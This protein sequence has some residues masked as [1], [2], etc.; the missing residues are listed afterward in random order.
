M[1]KARHRLSAAKPPGRG[2]RE[3][4]AEMNETFDAIRRGRVDAVVVSAPGGDKVFTLQGAEHPYRVLVEAMNEGAATLDL[5]GTVLYANV[6]F[7]EMLRV[8]LERLIGSELRQ[9]VR[10]ESRH[11]IRRILAQAAHRTTRTQVTVITHE[12]Q[13]K[14]LRISLSPVHDSDPPTICAVATEL[15]ELVEANE[16]LKA[17]E[18][19]LRRLSGRLLQ[20]QD[21]ERRHIAR[22]LH[23]VTGQKVA[24]QAMTLSHVL[25]DH[26]L[27]NEDTRRSLSECLALT[28]QVANEIR[29]LSYLLHPPLL[30]ELGL[31]SA[32]KWY[33]QGFEARTG[34]RVQVAVPQ[35]FPRLQPDV[36]VALFRVLQESLTNV[37]RYS[38]SKG[39]RIALKVDSSR[40][41]LRVEDFGK[42]IDPKL[43]GSLKTKQGALG[44][45]IQGMRERL[46]Q[47]RGSLD[48]LSPKSGGTVVNAIVPLRL[49]EEPFEAVSDASATAVLASGNGHKADAVASKS[50]ILI[51]DDHEVLRRGIRTM[52]EGEPCWEVCGEAVDGQEAVEK[53][54]QLNPDLVIL[55]I[56]MPVLNGLAAL[57][58]VLQSRPNTKVLV[59]SVHNSE[60]MLHESRSAGAHGYVSKAR[61]SEDLLRAVKTVLNGENFYAKPLEAL[62]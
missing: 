41:T 4:I 6:Q 24:F 59:F 27:A 53:T 43:L 39:A 36:E 29:T 19:E 5:G 40:V 33:V 51:A 34:I 60:Q 21:E 3:R 61:A 31:V 54:L 15:T 12:G 16:A 7:A 18:E 50:R 22:D 32:L 45:G 55:D 2:L 57:R 35:D 17:N 25:D 28:H 48:I 30:D 38:G 13:R 37:H 10:D 47:L 26:R 8:P 49:R 14:L 62:V 1:K 20:L 46:R 9:H 58:R 56:N 42:G 23:D 44:V 11:R 52:L